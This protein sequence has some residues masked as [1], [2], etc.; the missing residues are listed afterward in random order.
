MY[1]YLDL[2]EGYKTMDQFLTSV[3]IMLQMSHLMTNQQNGMCAQISLGICPVRSKSLLFAWRKSLGPYL[4]TDCTEK[5]DQTG[6]QG[7]I[8]ALA[9]LLNAG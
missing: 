8:L 5:T 1:S 3:S 9:N 4:P 6:Q 2:Y 7:S